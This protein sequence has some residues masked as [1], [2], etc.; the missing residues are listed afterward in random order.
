MRTTLPT[1]VCIGCGI[2][3][4]LQFFIPLPFVQRDLLQW[5]ND[6]AIVVATFGLAIGLASLVHVH[7]ARIR[8]RAPGWA[9]SVVTLLCAVVVAVI[10]L[11]KPEWGPVVAHSRRYDILPNGVTA[12]VIEVTHTLFGYQP[13][14]TYTNIIAAGEALLQQQRS[15]PMFDWFYNY[16]MY[17]LMS[18]VFALL[19][20][21]MMT[22]AFRAMR[23]KSWEAGLL[24]VAALIVL[25]GQVPVEQFVRLPEVDGAS[26]FDWLKQRILEYPNTAAKRSIIIGVALGG[27]ATSIK[28]LAGIEKPYLGGRG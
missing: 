15:V 27:L 18:T 2:I 12:G 9:L 21:Y 1:I 14:T 19:A 7:T 28:I 25:L 17:P 4:L 23:A 10:G 16:I 3:M 20:F 8:R 22:A 11:L 24:L 13:A 6:S 26:V 5:V